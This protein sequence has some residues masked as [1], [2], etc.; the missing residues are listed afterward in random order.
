MFDLSQGKIGRVLQDMGEHYKWL[1]ST[2]KAIA[3]APFVLPAQGQ[4]LVFFRIRLNLAHFFNI[5]SIKKTYCFKTEEEKTQINK[6][7][8]MEMA[9]PSWYLL[10]LVSSLCISFK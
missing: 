7:S 9:L 2:R 8:G 1:Q 6:N 5:K 3:A 10:R 4:Y